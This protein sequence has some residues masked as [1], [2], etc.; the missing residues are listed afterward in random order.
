MKY[1]YSRSNLLPM[2]SEDSWANQY[3]FHGQ[4]AEGSRLAALKR[5]QESNDP[6]EQATLIVEHRLPYPVV[7][8]LVKNITP[9]V[10]VALIDVMSPQELLQSLNALDKRGAL[11][12]KDVKALVDKKLKE[13]KKSTGRLDAMKAQTAAKSAKGLDAETRAAVAEIT[14][15]QLKRHG[16][17]T[18][19]MAIFIDMSYSMHVAIELGKMAAAAIA[20]ACPADRPPFVYL[21]NN[22]AKPIIW[23]ERDGDIASLSAWQKKL[24]MVT[25]NGGTSP[26]TAVRAMI[27]AKQ[28]VEQILVVTDEGENTTGGF[29]NELKKYEADFGAPDI[30]IARCGRDDRYDKDRMTKT[31]QAAGFQVDVLE[32]SDIDAVSI[33]NLVR[34]LSRK[35]IFDLMQD[36]QSADLPM[37]ESW[38]EK[39]LKKEEEKVPVTV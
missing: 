36:I 25:A 29:A 35:S 20:Q 21:F 24:E 14:D 33:P 28:H 30:V 38:D 11:A 9:T 3:L 18:R 12:N 1:L 7:S 19:P 8:A 26:N 4:V 22:N 16:E 37:R 5:L 31:C 2:G 27:R 32:C 39:F 34:I 10:L 17:I 13:A 23:T 6:T 15:S